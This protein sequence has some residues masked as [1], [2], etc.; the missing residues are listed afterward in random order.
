MRRLCTVLDGISVAVCLTALFVAPG[1]SAQ[2]SKPD[3]GV[4]SP[5]A[6]TGFPILPPI[7]GA[8]P[9]V[10]REVTLCI[11]DKLHVERTDTTLSA[12]FDPPSL[13]RVRVTVGKNMVMGIKDEMRVYA[14]G[15][16]RPDQASE[17]SWSGKV[18][19]CTAEGRASLR[20]IC[21]GLNRNLDGI[22]GTGK[23]YIVE[24]ALSVFETDIPAQ[25]MWHP[26]TS[27]KYKVLWSGTLKAVR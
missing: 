16:P 5:P 6:F 27:K 23:K 7:A 17:S 4:A 15:D 20:N 14:V 2:S 21:G 11:P 1:V 3:P 13:Q 25:H 10:R 8:D 9:S 18:D 26:Q 19:F 24:M 22:P 12:Q